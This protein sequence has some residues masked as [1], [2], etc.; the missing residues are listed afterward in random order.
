MDRAVAIV[1]G[2]AA[3]KAERAPTLELAIRA[4]WAACHV[5]RDLIGPVFAAWNASEGRS[6]DV[7]ELGGVL[8]RRYR[9]QGPEAIA[10]SLR[11]AAET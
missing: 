9:K 6:G 2:Y 11:R 3:A 5:D 7:P 4:G 8:R 10:A 1:L